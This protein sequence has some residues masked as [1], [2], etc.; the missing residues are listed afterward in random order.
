MK[1]IILVFAF[2]LN[3]LILNAQTNTFDKYIF[4]HGSFEI[5]EVLE[6]ENQIYLLCNQTNSRFDQNSSFLTKI[7]YSGDSISFHELDVSHHYQLLSFAKN[8]SGHLCFVGGIDSLE[9]NFNQSKDGLFVET[10]LQ[11][12]IINQ[13]SYRMSSNNDFY[14]VLV[15]GSEYYV[16]G[17]KYVSD[18]NMDLQV[19]RIDSNGALKDSMSLDFRSVDAVTSLSKFG[20]S[21]LISGTILSGANDGYISM[22]NKSLDTVYFKR[23]SVFYDINTNPVLLWYSYTSKVTKDNNVLYPCVFMLGNPIDTNDHNIYEHSGL[24]ITDKNGNLKS[25]H[26]YYLDARYDRPTEIFETNNGNY[27]IAGT[28]NFATSFGIPANLNGDFYLMKVDTLGNILWFKRYGDNNYQ[29]MKSVIRTSDGG[30]VMGGYSITNYSTQERTG[31]IVKTDSIGN[32]ALGINQN[33]NVNA[34][35][36]PNPAKNIIMI[37]HS[38]KIISYKIIDMVG[39]EVSIG[40]YLETGVNIEN[41]TSG[42]YVVEIVL[43]DGTSAFGKLMVQ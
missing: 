4:G 23:F 6:H 2:V 15:D 36:Y 24:I 5:T 19:V 26:I 3:G 13:K 14:N 7:D 22:I 42:I 29:E 38:S 31:Y 30:F 20:D 10:D 33:K 37:E 12:N 41:L 1:K 25:Q 21:L 34:K 43:V 8:H 35:I 9:S 39:K 32:V 17:H 16:S 40:E 27:I 18:F 11:G 28:I